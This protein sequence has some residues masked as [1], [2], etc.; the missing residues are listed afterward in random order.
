MTKKVTTGLF[1]K[2]YDW[3]P[4][5]LKEFREFLGISQNG[6]SEDLG[7]NA[8]IGCV[9]YGWESGRSKIAPSAKVLLTLAAQI[10]G[11]KFDA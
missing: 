9:V 3:T 7:Y 1:P 2:P 11:Y 10:K 5:K 8:A 4:E 6:L